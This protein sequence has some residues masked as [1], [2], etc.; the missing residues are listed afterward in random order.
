VTPPLPLSLST[1]RRKANSGAFHARTLFGL[2]AL[3]NTLLIGAQKSGTTSLFHY[4]EQH[5]Q[6]CASRSKEPQYFD[7]QYH[8]GEKWYRAHFRPRRGETVR[9]EASPHSLFHPLSPRRVQAAIPGARL[10]VLLR[11]PIDRAYSHYHESVSQS[12]EPLSFRDALAAEPAR[13]ADWYEKVERGEARDSPELRDFSYVTRG[14]YAAQ[15]ARWLMPFRREQFLFLRSE[16]MFEAPQPT[17]DRVYD[18]LGID[19][20][21]IGD[22][23]PRRQRRYPPME[24]D[25]RS[26]LE[27]TFEASNEELDSLTGITWS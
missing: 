15:I 19:S 7:S 25:I 3:P 1:L 17:L 22:S 20:I 2:G 5:P 18:S 10:I 8:R 24:A 27:L 12:A 26:A 9:I 16:E 4:L 14:L 23:R 13:L 21:A 6:I 11:N